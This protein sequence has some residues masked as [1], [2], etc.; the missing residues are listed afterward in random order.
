MRISTITMRFYN[1]DTDKLF[2]LNG[3]PQ[4][5][6]DNATLQ[7]LTRVAMSRY[8][9]EFSIV[10]VDAAS[11]KISFLLR[12]LVENGIARQ[13]VAEK[14]ARV[15]LH[16][17]EYSVRR[18]KWKTSYEIKVAKEKNDL[19]PVPC[20]VSQAG[21]ESRVLSRAAPKAITALTKFWAKLLN[22]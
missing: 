2:L 14:S 22:H 3:P 16:L 21:S 1:N 12:H 10:S 8:P 19:L 18:Y 17:I 13:D 6:V 15:I 7:R 11:N 20:L 9:R 5:R 4:S